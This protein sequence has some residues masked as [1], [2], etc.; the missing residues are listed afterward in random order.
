MANKP[1]AD[2]K[3]RLSRTS[4]AQAVLKKERKKSNY[5]LDEILDEDKS[6]DTVTGKLPTEAAYVIMKRVTLEAGQPLNPAGISTFNKLQSLKTTPA[7][8]LLL[9]QTWRNFFSKKTATHTSMAMAKSLHPSEELPHGLGNATLSSTEDLLKRQKEIKSHLSEVFDR[10]VQRVEQLWVTMK[11]PSADRIFYRKSLCKGPPQSVEQCREIAQYIAVLK[12]HQAATIAVIQVIQIREMAIA[13]CF[14]V[15][16]ALQRKFSRLTHRDQSLGASAATPMGGSF[17]N[18]FPASSPQQSPAVSQHQQHPHQFTFHSQHPQAEGGSGG[19][20]FWKEELIGVLDEVRAATMEVVR[21]VQLWRRNL[22][23]PHPFVYMGVNYVAKMKDDLGILESDMY[24]KLLALVPLKYTD[25]QCVVFFSN[26]GKIFVDTNGAAANGSSGNLKDMASNA[27]NGGAG[28]ASAFP[29]RTPSRLPPAYP[30][31]DWG[32]SN[33]NGF[34]KQVRVKNLFYF[35]KSTYIPHYNNLLLAL[36][37][38]S[39]I[40]MCADP[41]RGVHPADAA[42]ILA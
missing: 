29:V 32:T 31:S 3:V 38:L 17:H 15:L 8:D 28:P 41:E 30:S 12:A 35:F 16:A 14:D 11:I 34:T 25:L 10:L 40:V 39:C 24:S 13:K 18:T 21:R 5:K 37:I 20:S 7:V 9:H 36:C 2:F 19:M 22:W 23:R 6:M 4:S 26:A 42:G 1:N 33:N 27:H